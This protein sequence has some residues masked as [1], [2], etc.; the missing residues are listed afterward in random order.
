[1]SENEIKNWCRKHYNLRGNVKIR[2]INYDIQEF[3]IL[4][5]DCECSIPFPK[6]LVRELKINMILV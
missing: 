2:R 1:M 3:I 4:L 5:G 6:S